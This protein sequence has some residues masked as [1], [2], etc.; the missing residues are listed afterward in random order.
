MPEGR[1]LVIDDDPKIARTFNEAFLLNGYKGDV[2]TDPLVLLPKLKNTLDEYELV[3]CD[4]RMPGKSGIEMARLIKLMNSR[5]R[6]VLMS[7]DRKDFYESSEP[8]QN[9]AD[10]FVVKPKNIEE[11]LQLIST[12]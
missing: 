5:I 6:V 7:S 2:F 10:T 8:V 12:H 4:M 9:F 11:V 3:I 1:I